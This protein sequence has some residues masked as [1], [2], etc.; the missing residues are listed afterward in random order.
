MQAAIA[1]HPRAFPGVMEPWYG[2]RQR[3]YGKTAEL[4]ENAAVVIAAEGS[5]AIG[6][7]VA[8]RKP[9]ILMNSAKFDPFVQGL[10]FAYSAELMVPLLDLDLDSLPT[11]S[12]NVD[13]NAYARFIEQYIKK[14][15]TP[16]VPFWSVVVSDIIKGLNTAH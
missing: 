9:L 8:F 5:T 14:A 13:E 7:A 12:L 1:A 15:G 6:I 16:E 3:I 10:T 11:I 2:G 4:I